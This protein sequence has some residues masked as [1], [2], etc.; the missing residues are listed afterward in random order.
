MK[1]LNIIVILLLTLGFTALAQDEYNVT[2]VNGK[3]TNLKTGQE[4]SAGDVLNPGDQLLFESIDSYAIAI[5][6]NMK[7]F[8]LK[9]HE[10]EGVKMQQMLTATVMES[11]RPTT[12]RNL[13]LARF[14][15][16]EEEISD[17][18]Q[19]FGNDKFSIIGDAVDVTLSHKQYPLSDE[20]FIVFYYRVDN[21]PVQKKIGFEEQKLLL[22]KEKLVTSSA[23]SISGNEIA[24]LQ[25]Y[26][27]ETTTRTGKEI[28]RFTL[29]FVDKETLKN[30]F[31]TIIPILKRQRMAD[32]D[33]KKYLIEYYYDF[34]GA[35]DSKTIDM[36]ADD[37]VKNYSM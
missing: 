37:I 32:P 27:Y 30:E 5:G 22:E 12:M 15:P 33:I 23:G 35:T 34:Y 16:N 2:R 7:R 20:K 31:Y 13:M 4:V 25:V 18:K 17:L 36:F 24:D 28:T 19:Y 26:E 14:N 1:T 10:A 8:Q 6:S 29:V 9:I 3:V 11:A 21:N